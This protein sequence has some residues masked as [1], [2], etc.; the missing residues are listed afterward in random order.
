[1]ALVVDYWLCAGLA[2]VN[3]G[4]VGIIQPAIGR[5]SRRVDAAFTGYAAPTSRVSPEAPLAARVRRDC[6]GAT[7]NIASPVSDAPAR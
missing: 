3:F 6:A 5:W 1:M 2:T 4:I 7:V